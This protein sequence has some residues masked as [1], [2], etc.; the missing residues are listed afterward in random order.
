MNVGD[1]V[2]L[3]SNPE[4]PMTVEFV[5]GSEPK[6]MQEK[7]LSRKMEVSGYENGDVYC[8]WFE[9]ETLKNA[10]FKIR[11]ITKK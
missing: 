10:I 5:L 4:V 3:N 9:G 1:V 7:M 8:T 6:G 11:M 2:F